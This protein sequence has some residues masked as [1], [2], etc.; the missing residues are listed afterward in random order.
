[1]F[2]V[3]HSF[4]SVQY[5]ERLINQL[6]ILIANLG[7]GEHILKDVIKQIND[8]RSNDKTWSAEEVERLLKYVTWYNEY[9]GKADAVARIDEMVQRYNISESDISF[10]KEKRISVKSR[11]EYAPEECWPTEYNS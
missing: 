1:M 11:W 9:F 6:I 3:W 10:L 5:M 4:L 2:A 7:G 8:A